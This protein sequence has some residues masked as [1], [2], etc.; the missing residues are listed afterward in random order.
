ML[1]QEIEYV[2][3]W[4]AP[5]QRPQ[6]HRAI[7][8][9][10]LDIETAPNEAMAS[11]LGIK[12]AED[13]APTTPDSH[14]PSGLEKE[15]ILAKPLPEIETYLASVNPSPEWLADLWAIEQAIGK[16]PR[17]G[18]RDLIDSCLQRQTKAA[19]AAAERSKLL[20]T[21]PELCRI[22]AASWAVDKH[23]PQS[24]VEGIDGTEEQ[25][26]DR[27]WDVLRHAETIVGYNC[28]AFDLPVILVRSMLLGAM[29]S[30][31]VD[32]SPYGH[33][34]TDLYLRRFGV[35]GNSDA[36]RPATLKKLAQV[37]GIAN[38]EPDTCG[39]DVSELLATDPDKLRSY[40]MSDVKITRELH[41]RMDGYFC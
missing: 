35:R 38:D 20:A 22:V 34:V 23:D 9:L 33:Q 6:I 37:Y 8:C 7:G 10:Y 39:A 27:L 1:T 26:L 25:L 3:E 12:P 15:A 28:L 18:V 2:I 17:K 32:L 30:R 11:V 36:R 31:R 16:K 19:A 40:V 24:F 21:T 29:P 41:K 4:P 13:A 5:Q 14:L